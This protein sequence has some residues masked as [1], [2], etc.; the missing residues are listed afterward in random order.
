ML[1]QALLAGVELG[2]N[3][4]LRM[5]ST[6]LPRLARLEGTVIEVDCQSPALKLFILPSEDGLQLAG[7]WGDADCTLSA[8]ASSLLRLALAKD[9]T[10][11]L[12][13]PEV[14]LSGESAVL[15]ELAGILQDLELDW[16][17]E[18]SRWLGPIGSTLLAGHLRSR[19]NWAGDS[20]DS[21]RQT[22]SDYLAEESRSL[23]GEREA[24][25]RFTEL[26]DLKLAL[27]R[28]DAR[29]ECLARRMKPD[30]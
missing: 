21:L 7:Q 12:H 11:I 6:A 1:T 9:K 27:D 24:Q 25:A 28:L 14:S 10:A 20:L 8:P 29:L 17:Y 16:E 23:V 5:D 4:V 26:D 2:L 15:L 3:R 18:L 19:V 22:L 13:R 30:A